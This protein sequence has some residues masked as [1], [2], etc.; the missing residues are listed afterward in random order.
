MISS[1]G[2]PSNFETKIR[3][4]CN[5]IHSPPHPESE[6]LLVLLLENA[7][8]WLLNFAKKNVLMVPGNLRAGLLS[9]EGGEV[10]D[11]SQGTTY[12]MQ[13]YPEN[14]LPDLVK[15]LKF[16]YRRNLFLCKQATVSGTRS[17]LCAIF[18]EEFAT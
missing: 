9:F 12:T 6:G 13:H 4:D 5:L 2:S 8:D 3:S 10:N 18:F 11:I 1:C 15:L 14:I 7:K 16:S 17:L